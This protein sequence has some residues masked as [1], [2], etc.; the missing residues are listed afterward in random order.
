MAWKEC[1]RVSR[2]EEFVRLGTM[3]DTN[4]AELCRRFG[5]SRKTGYKWLGR[6]RQDPEGSLQDRSHR[7]RRLHQP[8]EPQVEAQVLQV[9][10]EHS[11][12][13]G[14]K[15]RRRL[16]DQGQPR[17]PAASTITS[18]LRRHGQIDPA[19]SAKHRPYQRFER[20][21]PND[22]W[23]M[24]F[25]GEFRLL[26]STYCYPLTVLDDHSRFAVGLRA[27]SNQQGTTV[28][29]ELIQLFRCYGLPWAI[30]ADNGPPWG[31]AHAPGGWTCLAIW[32]LRLDIAVYHGRP[33]H[34]QTQGKDERFHRTL[35]LEVLQDRSIRD[36]MHAQSLFDPW[37]DVYNRIRPHEALGLATP[38]S[39]YRPS[40]RAYPETLP[41]LEYDPGETVRQVNNAGYFWLGCRRC[42]LG[43]AFRGQA[44]AVRPTTQDGL[45]DI[46]YSRHRIGQLDERIEPTKG[47]NLAV[48][49]PGPRPDRS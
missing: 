44:I 29:E 37:R 10:Q 17:V 11:A 40:P 6:Y 7:P 14:R 19:E 5:I 42:W 45:W 48:V 13:G 41:T 39:R 33:R 47:H 20:A 4:I 1:D 46:Y 30:L 28:Q 38:I 12:W 3:E 31:A 21:A 27:C 22:L 43:E 35:D 23:Q 18:I 16:Q 25:K 26:D 34:P 2:R 8:T 36:G 15:I 32:L 49:R 9:R 24:D